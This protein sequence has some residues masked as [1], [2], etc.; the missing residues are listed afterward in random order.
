MNACIG[1]EYVPFPE[2]LPLQGKVEIYL[3]KCIDVMRDSLRYFAKT[4]MLSYKDQGCADDGDLRG[5]WLTK[6]QASQGGLLVELITWCELVE[7]SFRDVTEGGDD[8]G[9]IKAMEKSNV[10]LMSLIQLT[11]TNLNKPTRQKVMC[12][13]TLDAHNRD[14]QVRL[15]N[16]KVTSPDAFQWQS[17]LKCVWLE[18]TDDAQMQICDA[19][20]PYG[21]EYLG[22]GPPWW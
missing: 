7:Q 9:V 20:F 4:D 12:A 15:M 18:E 6:V 3:D 16:E 21:Y 19:R 1:V 5:E 2:P 22:N 14:V 10:L 13:I 11:M 17:M 8:Q